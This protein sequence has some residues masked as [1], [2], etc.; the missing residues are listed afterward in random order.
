MGATAAEMRRFFEDSLSAGRSKRDPRISET[1][2]RALFG[3]FEGTPHPYES[4]AKQHRRNP[5]LQ[6]E[7]GALS[8]GWGVQP[9]GKHQQSTF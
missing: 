6:I 4:K 3:W 2:I 1:E 7:F 9:G 5:A 8:W